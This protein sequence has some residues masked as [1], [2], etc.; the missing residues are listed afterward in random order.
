M[1]WLQRKDIV[2]I[3]RLIE[4]FRVALS[5]TGRIM[6]WME[7]YSMLL[8]LCIEILDSHAHV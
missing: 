8:I 2:W 7:V 4:D 3:S 1:K 5:V 6:D